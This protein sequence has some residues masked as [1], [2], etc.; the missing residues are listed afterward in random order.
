[1]VKTESKLFL[2]IFVSEWFETEDIFWAQLLKSRLELA[3]S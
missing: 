3:Q 1:M 2:P